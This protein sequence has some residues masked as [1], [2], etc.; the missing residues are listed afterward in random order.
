MIPDLADLDAW[1]M[2]SARNLA[3]FWE[4]IPHAMGLPCQRWEAAWAAD[5]NS[6]SPYPNSA[7]LLRPLTE[8]V[9]PKLVARLDAFYAGQPGGPWLIWSAWPT[10]DLSA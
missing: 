6:L 5:L 2:L 1:R 8:D 7:T 3:A 4:Y 9:A 10:P